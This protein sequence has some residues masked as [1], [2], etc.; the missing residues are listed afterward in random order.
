MVFSEFWKTFKWLL[1][2]FAVILL[3]LW[4]RFGN[5]LWKKMGSELADLDWW[6]SNF[7]T[8]F[9][10]T[11]IVGLISWLVNVTRENAHR[12]K[13]DN[14]TLKIIWKNKESSQ[15]L[16]WEEFE[17]FEDS[18]FERWKLVKS[19][20]SGIGNAKLT[21]VHAA[22][23]AGWVTKDATHKRITVDLDKACEVGH[24]EP[25]SGRGSSIPSKP[26]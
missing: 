22:E 1:L 19:V 24:V 4:A 16:F 17:R 11:I 8:F 18:D 25:R 10:F 9:V 5:A 15:E 6:A 3:V 12:R 21:T 7:L 13:Y 20:V 14:W 23:D 26:L 2:G